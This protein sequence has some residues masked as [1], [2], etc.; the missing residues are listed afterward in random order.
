[1][2]LKLNS[3][4]YQTSI[5]FDGEEALAVLSK[6]TFDLIILDLIMPKTDGFAVLTFLNKSGINIPVV[7]SSNLSQ[8]E[9][10]E[11]AKKLG[12][13]DF[14]VKSNVTLVDIVDKVKQYL[15]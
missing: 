6:E 12:A 1:M 8:S 5:V 13:V 2:A 9:D 15:Q 3:A 14:F 7:V 11:K 4:G 10:L